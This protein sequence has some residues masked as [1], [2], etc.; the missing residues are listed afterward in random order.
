MG[1]GQRRDG[2]RFF[3]V[4]GE[5][6]AF[7]LYLGEYRGVPRVRPLA[8]WLRERHRKEI[9]RTSWRVYVAEAMRGLLGGE[10]QSWWDVIHPEPIDTR[11][12]D[13]VALYVIERVGIEIAQGGEGE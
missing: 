4:L 9:E 10:G 5:E 8:L 7:W 12:G 13:E 1:F 3:S 6:G 2:E 11:T